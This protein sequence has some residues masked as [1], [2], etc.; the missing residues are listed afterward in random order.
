MISR[1]LLGEDYLAKRVP[2]VWTDLDIDTDADT[3]AA[4]ARQTLERC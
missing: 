2:R 1:V 3:D 4:D